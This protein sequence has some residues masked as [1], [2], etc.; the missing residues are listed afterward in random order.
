[1][2]MMKIDHNEPVS[3]Q[4]NNIPE[5]EESL[6]PFANEMMQGNIL[7]FYAFDVGDDI[8]IASI[9]KDRMIDA[10]FAAASPYFKNY[11]TPLIVNLN[12]C[13]NRKKR[14]ENRDDCIA[15]KVHHFGVISFCYKISFKA[16]FEEIRQIL[17]DNEKKYEKISEQD[18]QVVFESIHR[19]VSQ[20]ICYNLKN[21]YCV[22]QVNPLGKGVDPDAFKSQYGSNIVSLLRFEAQSLSEHQTEDVLA[23]T[24]GYYGQDF[25][26]IDNEASFIY[27]D[28]YYE[29]IEFFE[30][31][32]IQK[33]E[34]Q[35]FDRLLDEKLNYF[36]GQSTQK[37]PL[38]SYIPFFRGHALASVYSLAKLRVDISVITERLE[39][40]IKMAGDPFYEHLY[41]MLIE[42][43]SL[44]TWKESINQKMTII[45][46]LYTVHQD[47]LT[48]GR[49]E[50]LTIVV[51]LLIAFESIVL[52][53]R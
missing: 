16:T 13:Y 24:T 12:D 46:D 23:S 48:T 42:R 36:Y 33:L 4:I 27:D 9:K 3:L 39:N 43:L 37:I 41:S 10:R 2:N 31:A 15:S 11:H 17:I 6:I 29:A 35:Y 21:T 44:K 49:A 25:V 1:M 18:C 50:A 8:A 30:F 7:L 5:K 19:A 38:S 14:K 52:F 45:K 28:D 22:V 47:N 40:S 20:P 53:I 51:I 26:I 32:N 34:L